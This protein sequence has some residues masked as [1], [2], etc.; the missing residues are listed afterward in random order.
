[1]KNRQN[2]K[3]DRTQ[4]SPSYLQFFPTAL[5][6]EVQQVYTE[7]QSWVN[8]PKKGFLRYREPIEAVAHL[9]ASS[10]DLD[11]DSVRIGRQAD[12]K[13]EEHA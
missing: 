4:R 11:Q 13:K 5:Q 7:K 6:E 3:S 10:L 2:K 1:M 9:R 8:Q 12:L